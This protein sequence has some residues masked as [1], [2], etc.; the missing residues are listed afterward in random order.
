MTETQAG[1][2]IGIGND[3]ENGVVA[4]YTVLCWKT[5]QVRRMVRSAFAVECV[6]MSKGVEMAELVRGYLAEFRTRGRFG[7]KI[8]KA[9]HIKCMTDSPTSMM[10]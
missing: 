10:Q 3:D 1:Y 2:I 9:A 7:L 6:A 5:H 4:P 8:P